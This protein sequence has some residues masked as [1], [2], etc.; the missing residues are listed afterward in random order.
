[1]K[2]LCICFSSKSYAC[3]KA[4]FYQPT[5]KHFQR[6]IYISKYPEN[7]IY[8]QISQQS[9][10]GLYNQR[11]MCFFNAVIQC[12]VQVEPLT[13]YFLNC[14]EFL[15]LNY[16]NQSGTYGEIT[17]QYG[18]L[19]RKLHSNNY[20]QKDNLILFNKACRW[21]PPYFHKGQQDAH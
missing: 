7:K 2:Y 12:L 13:H 18:I 16:W 3:S 11:N 5:S 21:H 14:R 9:L 10:H 1:M 19:I 8:S 15:D 17:L 6:C 20:Q 4:C